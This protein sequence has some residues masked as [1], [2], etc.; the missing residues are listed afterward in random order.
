MQSHAA[1]YKWISEIIVG[2]WYQRSKQMG[3]KRVWGDGCDLEK[4]I[5]SYVCQVS[6]YIASHFCIN[7]TV[8]NFSTPLAMDSFL[9]VSQESMPHSSLPV[10]VPHSILSLPSSFSPSPPRSSRSLQCFTSSTSPLLHYYVHFLSPS[11]LF[12]PLHL[13]SYTCSS[14]VTPLTFVSILLNFLTSMHTSIFKSSSNQ[15]I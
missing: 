7:L 12:K 14:A 10:Y 8:H 9:H 6:P 5:R 13:P 15:L 11:G 4:Y 3:L 2:W 1:L